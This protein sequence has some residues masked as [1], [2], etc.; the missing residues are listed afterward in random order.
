MRLL[1]KV[2]NTS[3]TCFNL[4]GIIFI[5]DTFISMCCEFTWFKV[6]C[7]RTGKFK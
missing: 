6:F 7:I 1:G 2:G 3:P 5:Y 4:Q